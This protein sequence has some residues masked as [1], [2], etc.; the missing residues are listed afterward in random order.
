MN[1]GD[2]LYKPNKAAYCTRTGKMES[3]RGYADAL[4]CQTKYGGCSGTHYVIRIGETV[5]EYWT[6]RIRERRAHNS[7]RPT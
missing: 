6:E 4:T 7:H 2:L 5:E 1:E 3:D